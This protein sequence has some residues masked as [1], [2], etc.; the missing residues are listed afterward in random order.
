MRAAAERSAFVRVLATRWAWRES[1]RCEAARRG[2]LFSARS[3]AR[4]RVLRDSPL[5]RR[6][7]AVRFPAV[8][9]GELRPAVLRRGEDDFLVEDWREDV[10]RLGLLRLEVLRRELLRRGPLRRELL[11]L[12]VERL[13][14]A[15]R[16]RLAAP[17]DDLRLAA[18]PDDL[19]LD[20]RGFLDDFA[21]DLRFGFSPMSTP[22]RRASESPIA[23]A[24]RAFLAPCSPP[25]ILSIS[26]RTNSP[27]CVLDDLP[28]RL[29]ARARLMVSLSGIE[30]LH[31]R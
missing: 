13:P 18:P 19:P 2:I 3:V 6:R 16:L 27:A 31:E 25:R 24:C 28:A 26:L 20:L 21:D 11:A 15:P 14:E 17:R 7:V 12:R 8:R 1:A 23:M 30:S 10:R 4:E 9:R 5:L 29:S 22:A